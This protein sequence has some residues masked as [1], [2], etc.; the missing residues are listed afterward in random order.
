MS[1]YTGGGGYQAFT[2][3]LLDTLSAPAFAALSSRKLSAGYSGSAMKVRRSSDNAT[4]NI[5][6]MNNVLDTAG[7]ASF[8]GSN[9]GFV[10]TF[11]DQSG[12]GNNCTQ[13][14]GTNQPRVVNLG[15][16][17]TQNGNVAPLWISANTNNLSFATP[18]SLSQPLTCAVCVKLSSINV[19]DAIHWGTG[20]VLIITGATNFGGTWAMLSGGL[21]SGGTSDT[22]IHMFIGVFNSTLSEFIID[23]STISGNAGSGSWTQPVSLGINNAGGGGIDGHICEYIAMNSVISAGD[24]SL[25]RASWQ[26]YWGTP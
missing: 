22:N 10:D 8:V 13:S 25:I 21:I 2:P 16:N 17:D 11:F 26:S 23:G 7:L 18:S 1:R 14:T 20:N 15:T 3:L 5:G 19:N 24:I 4:Q 9:S 6:F 12:N